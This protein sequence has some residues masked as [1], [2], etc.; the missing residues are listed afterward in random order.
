MKISLKALSEKVITKKLNI[1]DYLIIAFFGILIVPMIYYSRSL[2]VYY[3]ADEYQMEKVVGLWAEEEFDCYFDNVSAELES[4]MKVGDEEHDAKGILQARLIHVYRRKRHMPSGL[5]RL[6]VRMKFLVRYLNG[7]RI[8][9]YT[10]HG[11]NMVAG[12]SFIFT[13]PTYSI[14]GKVR[15]LAPL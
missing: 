10:Y 15:Q 9:P 14:A 4:L 5:F 13:T 6:D 8:K 12:Q 3:T 1:V 2:Y 7:N 11:S